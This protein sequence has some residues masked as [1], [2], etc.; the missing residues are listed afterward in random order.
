MIKPLRLPYRDVRSA[1][2]SMRQRSAPGG[3]LRSLLAATLQL[4]LFSGLAT[5]QRVRVCGTPELSVS[6]AQVV[7][8]ELNATME[9]MLGT[10]NQT[11][12]GQRL[13]ALAAIPEP[14]NAN[15][16]TATVAAAKPATGINVQV[17]FH[18]LRSGLAVSQG[19]VPDSQVARQMQVSNCEDPLC[20]CLSTSASSLASIGRALSIALPPVAMIWQRL[21]TFPSVQVISAMYAQTGATFTLAATDRTTN[22]AWYTA[23]QN[24]SAWRAMTNALHKGGVQVLRHLCGALH[25]SCMGSLATSWRLSLKWHQSSPI[26]RRT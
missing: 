14:A 24:S 6:A 15:A 26:L 17:Y 20:R 7:Q 19:N 11:L 12:A 23:A 10:T 16:R 22:A 2:A 1:A 25:V 3:S 18:V 4:A 5:A 13:A 8:K 21:C 9:A